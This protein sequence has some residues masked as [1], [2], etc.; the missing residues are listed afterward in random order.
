MVNKLTSQPSSTKSSCEIN[1]SRRNFLIGSGTAILLTSLPGVSSPL[2]ALQQNYP[3]KH[4]ASL[5]DLKQDRP[6]IFR[7]PYDDMRCTNTLIKLGEVAGAGV[8]VDKDIV[9]FNNLCPHM[10]GS[11]TD[12]Y[13]SEHKVAGPCPLHLTTY[14][15]TRHGMVISGH[16]TESLPQIMLSVEKGEIYAMSVV[17]LIFSFN[18]NHIL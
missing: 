8:G 12:V 9:A 6:F 11:I 10:G 3:K 2:R 14:D 17:G 1:L 18:D 5:T 7:Y 16:A 15:L 4:I 13:N